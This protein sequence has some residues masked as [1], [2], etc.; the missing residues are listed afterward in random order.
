S[1]L[2]L[3]TCLCAQSFRTNR[4][5][6]QESSPTEDADKVSLDLMCWRTTSR[7]QT[8]IPEYTFT[9]SQSLALSYGYATSLDHITNYQ[10]I[11]K[12]SVVLGGGARVLNRTLVSDPKSLTSGV[13][14]NG[15]VL[16]SNGAT[17]G[18]GSVF[19]S[20]GVL[21][22]DGVLLGH[23]VLIGAEAINS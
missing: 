1:D 8:T 13:Q 5:K 4:A 11:Y 21:I 3:P 20:L 17:M 22:G 16:T 15:N 14:A 10:G 12:T 2:L 18:D 23:G 6:A 7:P 9:W 19:L